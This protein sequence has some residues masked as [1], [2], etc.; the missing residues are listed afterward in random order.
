MTLH[1]LGL[2]YIHIKLIISLFETLPGQIVKQCCFTCFD[3]A[4]QHHNLALL[5]LLL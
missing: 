4:Q 1:F 5:L 3:I 2:Q